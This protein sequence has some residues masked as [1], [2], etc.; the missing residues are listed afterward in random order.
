MTL[1]SR[2]SSA[3]GLDRAPRAKQ[4]VKNLLYRLGDPFNRGVPLQIGGVAIKV[5]ARFA[6]QP[7][8]HYEPAATRR[9]AA[10]LQSRPDAATIDVGS[11]VALYSLLTL[12]LSPRGEAWAIDADLISLQSSRWLCKHVGPERLRVIR[13]YIGDQATLTVSAEAACAE[14]IARLSRDETPSEPSLANYVCLD[15]QASNDIP[16]HRVDNLFGQANA[17]RPWLMKID[18]EGAEMLVLRGAESFVARVR[19]QL[20]VSVHPPALRGYGLSPD[21]IRAWLTAR[22]YQIAVD[23]EPHEEHWWCTHSA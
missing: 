17:S 22:G 20:M 1:L 4:S 23:V 5:P 15:T 14:T 18:V 12:A 7:W 13:G 3:S 2:L 10:W 9:V 16:V 21:D 6:R 19:P 8:T 11:S